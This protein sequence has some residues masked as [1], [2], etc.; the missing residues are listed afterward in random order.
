MK[1]PKSILTILLLSITLHGY[2]QQDSLTLHYSVEDVVVSAHKQVLS[3]PDMSG[4]ISINMDALE[5]MPRFGGAVDVVKLLQYTPGVM[6]TEEGNT[7]LYV[8]GGDNGQSCILI[9]G[10]PL[11]SPSHLLGIFSTLNSAHLSGLT[12]YKSGIPA[13]YGSST[14]SVTDIR[15]HS[16][17]PKRLSVEGNIGLIESDAAVQIPVSEKSGIFLS[18]R[19]SYLSP[20]MSILPTSDNHIAYDFGDYGIGA[21]AELGKLGRLMIN[22]H[23]NNDN[24]TTSIGN[25]N[26]YGTLKLWNALGNITLESNIGSRMTTRN[27]IYSSIY[28]NLFDIGI[29]GNSYNVSAGVES[30]GAKSLT[31]IDLGVVKL[32]TG[33]NF[34]YR[35]VRPQHIIASSAKLSRIVE[36]TH[37]G[38]LFADAHWRVFNDLDLNTGIRLSLYK[39]DR[40]WCYPEPRITL[41]MPLSTTARIWASYNFMV[42][43]MHLAPQSNMSFATDFYV[44]SSET[45]P[46]QTSHNLALGYS[47]R[48]G[49]LR[50]ST[51]L[52][53]RYMNGVIE[54]HA[55]IFDVVLG[56]G[57]YSSS[58]Y[59]GIGESYGL[60]ANI[61][62]TLNNFELQLNYTL[63][64]S[65]RQFREINNGNPYP[66]NSDRRH[67]L[68]MLATWTPSPR[69]ILSAT[70]VYATGAPYTATE[71]VYINGNAFLR[72]YGNYNHGK[73][74]D[75]H[76]LDLSA[77][78]WLKRGKQN[79]GINISIYNIYAHRN[80]IMLSWH[81]S[82]DE[83][84]RLHIRE[85]SHTLYTIM[86]SISWIYKF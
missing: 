29:T 28:D 26:S 4:N 79:S 42:Q 50:Y 14:A 51:E 59:T 49:S 55:S 74:P 58:I 22:T 31:A 71:G 37:E 35:K 25:Y 43:Y 62:Y 1:R 18:A 47:N 7:A 53:Y 8:R 56:R 54:Y 38:A 60:E 33:I 41:S 11:Y 86:P 3:E 48:K 69:W 75:L 20:I 21:V 63:S 30:Y 32:Q 24:T 66:A 82:F 34:E 19:H 57:R 68:S 83:Q 17:A 52:Y 13:V 70:F 46:P 78:Y 39:N 45:I 6:A 2:A 73:L 64:R 16:F 61:G 10:V 9:N 85:K 80:P 76:H 84:N 67:N 15:T 72:L 65:V 23:F 12:L 5:G 44:S 27:T 81:V 40:V 36:Q 77:T